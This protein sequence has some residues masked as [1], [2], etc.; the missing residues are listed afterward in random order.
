MSTPFYFSAKEA[1]AHQICKE[2]AAGGRLVH[3]Y[4]ED[5]YCGWDGATIDAELLEAAA[6]DLAK[7]WSTATLLHEVARKW[8]EERACEMLEEEEEL[9]LN[10]DAEHEAWW[11]KQAI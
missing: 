7:D 10:P 3:E 8:F 6:K 5:L 9:E 11:Q 2:I 4:F 1:K